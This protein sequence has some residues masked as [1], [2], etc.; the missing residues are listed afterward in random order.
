MAERECSPQ[1]YDPGHEME[2]RIIDLDSDYLKSK[3]VSMSSEKTALATACAW[4]TAGSE[5]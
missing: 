1:G 5:A 2:S 3:A 4:S